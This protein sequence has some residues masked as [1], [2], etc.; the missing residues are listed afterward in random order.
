MSYGYTEDCSA[1]R[2]AQ[3]EVRNLRY[4]VDDVRR[5]ADSARSDVRDEA[6]SRRACDDE[7]WNAVWELQSQVAELQMQ[8][9]RA[10]SGGEVSRDDQ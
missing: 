8:W 9:T 1:G 7:L 4:D 2:D 10:R 6:A 3:S 5:E